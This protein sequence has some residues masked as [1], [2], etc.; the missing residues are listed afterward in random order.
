MRRGLKFTA[1]RG[2]SHLIGRAVRLLVPMYVTRLV[3]ALVSGTLLDGCALRRFT[4]VTFRSIV[5]YV[6]A[7][8]ATRCRDAGCID[9]EIYV[10]DGLFEHVNCYLYS[11][12]FNET[13]R[14]DDVVSK[15]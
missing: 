6:R 7:V 8:I 4:C 11:M 2:R 12:N 14:D 15:S 10:I 13:V 1:R 3:V 5:C 9:Q